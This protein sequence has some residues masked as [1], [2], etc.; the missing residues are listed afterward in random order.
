MSL[1]F[2]FHLSVTKGRREPE[3]S[4]GRLEVRGGV[5][6]LKGFLYTVRIVE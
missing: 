5:L 6:R 3:R 4:T 2:Y 1:L